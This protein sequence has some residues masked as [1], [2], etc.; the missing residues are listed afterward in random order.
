MLDTRHF[1]REFTLKLL[2]S[3]ENL[4][5]NLDGVCFHSENFQALQLMQERYQEQVKC[6]Y[7][8]PPYNTSS[9]AILYKNNY[10]HSS[11]GTLMF[12]RLACLRECCEKTGDFREHRQNGTNYSREPLDQVFGATIALKN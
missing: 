9:S 11:W 3:I 1:G 8:D 2:A 6:V 10:K 5:A 7:I 12:D 4:D